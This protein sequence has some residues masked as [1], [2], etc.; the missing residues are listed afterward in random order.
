VIDIATA[1]AGRAP[2]RWV[3]GANGP[4]PRR[5]S[6]IRTKQPGC[7]RRETA[8]I[9]SISVRSRLVILHVRKC[10]PMAL[11]AK[12]VGC[13]RSRGALMP[14]PDATVRSN[15]RPDEPD[16][17]HRRSAT[18]PSEAFA[19]GPASAAYKRCSNPANI[20]AAECSDRSAHGGVFRAHRMRRAGR[21][22]LGEED[23]SPVAGGRDTCR[24][25]NPCVA[26]S[27]EVAPMILVRPTAF[28]IHSSRGV[29]MRLHGLLS[30]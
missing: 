21:I 18:P 2:S 27:Q 25:A 23:M 6:M 14:A 13:L 3:T 9:R 4:H 17:P 16:Q 19:E 28:H 29:E 7:G 30:T 10:P 26:C 22:R 20:Q 24:P 8:T 15:L 12:P 1:E 5:R 11:T